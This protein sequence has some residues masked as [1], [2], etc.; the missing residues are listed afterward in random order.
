M[1]KLIVIAALG[2]AAL[3]AAEHVSVGAWKLNPAKSKGINPEPKSSVFT[4][5]MDGNARTL[6]THTV[7]ADGKET[8]TKAT[9]ILDGK[10]H[11]F[12]GTGGPA[13]NTYVSRPA[14]SHVNTTEFKKAGQVVRTVKVTYSKDGKTR[15][16]RAKG[17]NAQ[18]TAYDTTAVYE[19]Q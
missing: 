6:E 14:G 4:A 16:M 18:G 17:I 1:N 19:R 12:T 9:L 11:P 15:T 5:T 10:E 2:V 7:A 3:T 8:H 13:Y